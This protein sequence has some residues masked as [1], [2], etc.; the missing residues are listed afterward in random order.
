MKCTHRL[1]DKVK[2]SLGLCLMID[3]VPFGTI[4]CP[5]FKK[6]VTLN[7]KFVVAVP[8]LTGSGQFY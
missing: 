2:H 3:S 4:T 6:A 7:N 1:A 8:V 5:L